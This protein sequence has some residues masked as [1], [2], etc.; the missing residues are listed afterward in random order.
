VTKEGHRGG[1]ENIVAQQM[2]AARLKQKYRGAT[3]DGSV[4][5]TKVSWHNK[6]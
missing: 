5:K 6:R 4:M 1:I 3:N 2:M